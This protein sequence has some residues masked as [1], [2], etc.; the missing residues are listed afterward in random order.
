MGLPYHFQLELHLLHLLHSASSSAAIHA[1]KA[2]LGLVVFH[3][4]LRMYA[5]LDSDSHYPT[6]IPRRGRNR[7]TCMDDSM[8][9]E[10]TERRHALLGSVVP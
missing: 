4:Q 3:L 8:R 10:L 6:Y 7:D 5:V 1:G 9:E 2:I